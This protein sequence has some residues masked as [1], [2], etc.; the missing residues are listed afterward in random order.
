M[1][2]KVIQEMVVTCPEGG[3]PGT[4]DGQLV[5]RITDRAIEIHEVTACLECEAV[6]TAVKEFLK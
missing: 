4:D 5:R 2:A 6:E 3:S 1:K